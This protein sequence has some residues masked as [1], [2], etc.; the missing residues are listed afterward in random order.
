MDIEQIVVGA[1]I[2]Y[3]MWV[4]TQLFVKVASENQFFA[5]PSAG[6]EFCLQIRSELTAGVGLGISGE[7]EQLVL[8]CKNS[9]RAGVGDGGF[10]NIVAAVDCGLR[11]VGA[12]QVRRDPSAEVV[13]RSGGHELGPLTNY[14]EKSP[15]RFPR[16]GG[17]GTGG[18]IN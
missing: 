8:L 11:A 14:G 4:I 17:V 7:P 5:V 18:S 9:G 2:G 12:A 6:S 15:A 10:H 13:T 16:S 3:Q 1:D